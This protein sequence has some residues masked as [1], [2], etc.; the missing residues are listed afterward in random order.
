MAKQNDKKNLYSQII[1]RIFF[2]HYKK[3]AA[4]FE[5]DREEIEAAAKALGFSLPPKNLGD[6]IYSFRYRQDLP[7]SIQKTCP[8]DT[9]WIISGAGRAKYRFRLVP[10]TRIVPQDRLYKIKVPNSTPEIVE[11][12]ALGDEQAVLARVRY[13]RLIDL[14]TGLVTYSLQNHLRTTV[15]E[16]GQ[17]EV[18]ELYVGVSKTGAQFILPVQAKGPSD[19]VGRVQ[20]EQDIAYCAYKFPDLVCRPIAVQLLA[21]DVIAMFELTVTEERV[22]ILEERHY[23]LVPADDIS[24]KDLE[25]MRRDQGP[26]RPAKK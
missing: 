5:F 13:N 20:L 8:A 22:H 19:R 15:K 26:A 25:I 2:A 10:V 6:L 14:F 1:E 21:E 3:G 9:E 24:G 4:S 23:R 16:I 18:D 12:N 11:Q 7:E 17:V